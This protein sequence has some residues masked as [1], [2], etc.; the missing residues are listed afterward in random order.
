MEPAAGPAYRAGMGLLPIAV[1]E[2][3]ASE[4][5]VLRTSGLTKRFGTL[6][7]VDGLD[8]EV[9]RGEVFGLLGP[10]GSGKSTTIGMILGLIRPTAGRVEMF[11]QPVKGN[12]WHA[13]R[14]VG[15]IIES[16]SF[17]PYLSGRQN[18]QII[19]RALGDVPPHRIEEALERVELLE[20]AGDRY[21]NYSLGM[22]QRLG[23]ASTL[24]R[25]PGLIILDEP[26]NGLDPSGTR[27][28]RALI[29]QLARE[30]R[31]VLLCSHLL[32]EVEQV[33][34]RVAIIKRGAKLAEGSVNELLAPRGALRVRVAGG[35]AERA[36]Q[37][38][39]ALPWV[40]DVRVE[41]GAYL[42][43]KGAPERAGEL[44]R[45]LVTNG[46]EVL[47]LVPVHPTL[48]S[49][50]LELTEEELGERDDAV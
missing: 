4:D 6:T 3:P 40:G 30:G 22:K 35:G 8:L 12:R 42:V 1:A 17:Y 13:L 7:A 28:V 39:A 46:I 32:H 10:N 15:A 29:P 23:I 34:H 5:V 11:G 45:A 50:F 36:A 2:P 19:V 20:R 37:M 25:D 16:P 9:R 41:N 27:E 44:N 18:L 38:A 33:C 49:V 43:V 26:T 21:E 14:R 31:A 47:E 48:E 24:L